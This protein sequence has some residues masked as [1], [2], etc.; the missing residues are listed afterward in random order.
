MVAFRQDTNTPAFQRFHNLII[1]VVIYNIPYII[2][3]FRIW[4][5]F[6]NYNFNTECLKYKHMCNMC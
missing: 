2:Y 1:R 5:C 4:Y 6:V 3:V